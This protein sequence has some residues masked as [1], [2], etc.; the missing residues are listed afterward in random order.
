MIK[1]DI[2]SRL[3]IKRE[4]KTQE[5][6]NNI[7]RLKLDAEFNSLYDIK[8]NCMIYLSRNNCKENINAYTQSNERLLNKARSLGVASLDIQY[9]CK[10]CQDS[11]F[12]NGKLCDCVE[13]MI[14]NEIY[15]LNDSCNNLP[16]YSLDDNVENLFKNTLQYKPMLKLYSELR[17]YRDKFPDLI[18]KNILICGAP[19]AGKTGAIISLTN[20][21]KEKGYTTLYLNSFSLNNIF[22]KYHTLPVKEKLDIIEPL[23]KV[24]YL[25]IDDLGSE[26]IFNNVT[27]E[28]LNMLIDTRLLEKKSTV[29]T[30]NLPLY[31]ENNEISLIDRYGE[32]IFSRITDK[33]RTFI[34]QLNSVD[35]LRNIIHK[36]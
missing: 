8:H 29:I 32:R 5:Y 7:A 30:S 22:L 27:I 20:S 35:N 6:Y 14:L 11:G 2:L 23:L 31:A 28:Y 16:P 33:R 19:G 24:D 13:T 1:R 18:I 21:L 17:K 36:K 3:A 25:A 10:D 4:R 15:K 9:D 12:I 26:Q 34:L